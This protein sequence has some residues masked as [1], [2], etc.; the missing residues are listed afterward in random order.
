LI[1][2]TADLFS[3]LTDLKGTIKNAILDWWNGESSLG[4]TLKNIGSTI[5]NA[6]VDW[7]KT[8]EFKK[9]Y[10]NT[11]QPAIDKV[12]EFFDKVKD[13]GKSIKDAIAEWWD[14]SVF[15]E[16]FDAIQEMLNSFSLKETIDKILL[17]ISK[18]RISLP[19]GIKLTEYWKIKVPTGFE[20]KD[21]YPLAGIAP[22]GST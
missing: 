22:D 20:W 1:S 13:F 18:A 9:I 5:K 14:N 19:V 12:L 15:K 21:F 17:F 4:E 8:S 16:K 10:E 11:I 3:K 6:I 2:S 7:W